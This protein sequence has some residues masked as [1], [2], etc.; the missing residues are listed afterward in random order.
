[1]LSVS[2]FGSAGRATYFFLLTEKRIYVRCGC[3]SGSLEEWEEK[4]SETHGDTNIAHAYL[5]LI[6]AVKLQFGID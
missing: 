6:P 4:V 5:A 1:M 3:F 2:G